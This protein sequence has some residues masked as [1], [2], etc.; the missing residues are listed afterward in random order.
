M[1]Q[2]GTLYRLSFFIIFTLTFSVASAQPLKSFSNEPEVYFKE[3][4]TLMESADKKGGKELAE[5]FEDM[6]LLSYTQARR[7]RVIAL[8]NAML[9]KRMNAIPNF[10]DYYQILLAFQNSNKTEQQF[11]DMHDMLEKSVTSMTS[12]KY[13]QLLNICESLVRENA[14]YQSQALVWK[15]N[16]SDFTFGFEDQPVITFPNCLLSGVTRSDSTKISGTSGKYYP[17]DYLFKGKNGKILWERAGFSE[18]EAHANL[19]NFEIVVKS[20]KFDA[21]STV[22]HFPKYFKNDILGTVSEKLTDNPASRDATYP[23]FTSYNNE[24]VIPGIFKDVDYLGGLTVQGAKLLASGSNENPATF[25]FNRNNQPFIRA[26]STSFLIEENSLQSSRAAIYIKV[27][28]DSIVHPGLVFRYLNDKRELMLLRNNEG[29]AKT[30]YFDSYHQIDVDVEV[31]QWNV[32]DSTMYFKAIPGAVE[33]RAL[34]ES[35]DYFREERYIEIK[36]M[37]EE[38]PLTVLRKLSDANGGRELFS[39]SE[40]SSF[41]RIEITQVRHILRRL[42]SMGFVLYDEDTEMVTLKPRLRKYLLALNGR[43]DYDVIQFYSNVGGSSNNGEMSLLNYDM[44]MFGVDRIF[45]SDSQNVVIYPKNQQVIIH[46]NRDFDFAGIVRAGRFEFFGKKFDFQYDRFRLNLTNVDSLRLYVEG[47]EKD[48]FGKYPLTKV[49][50]VIE[51]VIGDL[52]IDHPNNK[53]GVRP[54][55]Q[56]PIFNSVQNSYAYYQRGSI[57]GGVYPRNTFYFQLDPYQVDSLDNFSNEGLVF[58]GTFVSAD[59]FPDLRERLSLQEDY[60]LGFKR[61]TGEEG[62][63]IYRGKGK[64]T[65]DI[66]MSHK[67]LRG[68][69]QIDYLTTTAKSDD[70]VFFPDSVNALC[71]S[72]NVRAASENNVEFP[73][74]EAADVKLHWEPYLPNKFVVAQTDKALVMYAGESKLKG[75][76]AIGESGMTGSG[77]MEFA[78]AEVASK[79]F[80]FRRDDFKSDTASFAFTARDAVNEDGTK[81]VAIKTDNV[82]ADVSFKGRMGQFK[83]NSAESFIEFPVNKYIAYMDELRWYMDKDEVDMNSSMNEIDLIGSRFVSTRP[84]QDSI[85]FVAPKAKYALADRTIRTEGVKLIRVADATIY[86]A[87]EKINVERNAVITTLQNSRISANNDTKYHDIYDATIDITAKRKYTASGNYDFEDAIGDIQKIRFNNIKQDSL[88]NTIASGE[89]EESQGFSFSPNFAFK[90]KAYLYAPNKG[91]NFEGGVMIGHNCEGLRKSWLKFKAQIDPKNIMIPVDSFPKSTENEKLLAGLVLIKD[92]TH[93]EP[94]F[95]APKSK[96]GD[97]EII[98][99]RGFLRFD[100]GKQEYQ[101]TTK[102]KFGN[103]SL[104]DD[105][106]A[107]KKDNCDINAEGYLSYGVDFGQVKMPSWGQVTYASA[108]GQ[109][110]IKGMLIVDFFLQPELWK[111]MEEAFSSTTGLQAADVSSQLYKQSLTALIGKE[112][113]DKVIKDLGS[114]GT[115]K[116][117]PDE[118]NKA[119]VFSNLELKWNNESSSWVS[120][121]WLSLSNFGKT[122]VNKV[123]KGKIE[124]VK[125]RGGDILNIYIEVDSNKWYFFNYTR[126]IMYVIA[127]EEAFNVAVREMDAKKRSVD[128]EDGKAPYQFMIGVEKRKRDFLNR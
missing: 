127:G 31:L 106:V 128:G 68:K 98:T 81:E 25:T 72:L 40:V 66:Q 87:Y 78:A 115:I 64:F 123:V 33:S 63:N 107:M 85:T 103:S 43:A 13:V 18:E 99:S 30:P 35:S 75:K 37:D 60:S 69:G 49:K 5:N 116:R 62:L 39:A 71:R 19:K 93:V 27:L 105:Y 36:G 89:I 15:S 16:T 45:L 119:L 58:D 102:E 57:L 22:F 95:L 42:S 104:S 125:K 10:R 79:E 11:N 65:N 1:Q 41:Y 61:N 83:S 17:Q 122:P 108:G 109:T 24:F 59:I 46:K 48:E 70:F 55:A 100:D 23:R 9:K 50:T 84:D 6:W 96:T 8:S 44:R 47:G 86:P 92:S 101:I 120:E 112:P 111:F 2:I 52:L 94:V 88:G 38:S 82:K 54:L 32:D 80:R 29:T 56:Y 76:I 121:G 117:F 77:T 73:D 51:N 4:K 114:T 74:V 124:L 3:M 14:L 97:E 118:L 67:G 12:G 21:D 126:N 113:A 110:T 34:F 53:S 28:E 91:L 90:G 7:A 20:N 26:S